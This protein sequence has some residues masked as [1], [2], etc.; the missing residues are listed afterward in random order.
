MTFYEGVQMISKCTQSTWFYLLLVYSSSRNSNCSS[1]T[2]KYFPMSYLRVFNALIVHPISIAGSCGDELQFMPLGRGASYYRLLLDQGACGLFGVHL[3]LHTIQSHSANMKS[4]R[5]KACLV[6]NCLYGWKLLVRHLAF[7]G[8]IHSSELVRIL[9]RYMAWLEKRIV[10]VGLIA[11]SYEL[12]THI[13]IACLVYSIFLQTKMYQ[14]QTYIF[15]PPS[16]QWQML[17]V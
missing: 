15:L 1:K 10:V 13:K 5:V 16:R 4:C 14:A 9:T 17:V 3:G 11:D 6:M 7:E 12:E 2:F 8:D